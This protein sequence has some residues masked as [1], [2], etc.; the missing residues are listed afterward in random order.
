MEDKRATS[1]SM[2]SDPFSQYN[3]EERLEKAQID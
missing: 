1:I 3:L 2:F